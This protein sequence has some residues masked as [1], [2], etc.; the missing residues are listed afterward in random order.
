MNGVHGTTIEIAHRICKEGF[1]ASPIGRAGPG[2]YFWRY[3][4][5]DKYAKHLAYKWWEHSNKAGNYNRIGGNTKCCYVSAKIE[6]DHCID[7]SHGIMREIIREHILTKLDEIKVENGKKM[8]EEEIIS[9]LFV[10]F[11]KQ[12]ENNEDILFDAL[13]ADVPAPK[14]ATG[15]IGKYIGSSAEAIIVINLE[16]IDQIKIE[17]T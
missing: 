14:G 16:K 6:P 7:F 4:S 2:V 11:V 5:S 1:Q 3:F 10:T 15:S 17:E 8:S 9:G 13:V 12:I